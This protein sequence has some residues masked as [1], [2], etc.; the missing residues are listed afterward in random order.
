MWILK[1]FTILKASQTV[2]R[3]TSATSNLKGNTKTGTKVRQSGT[4]TRR[5]QNVYEDEEKDRESLAMAEKW[6]LERGIFD[7][8]TQEKYI[9]E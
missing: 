9:K 4:T 3:R 6:Y 8:K 1:I 7:K 2:R 5:T